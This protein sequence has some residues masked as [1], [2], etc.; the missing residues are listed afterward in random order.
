MNGNI[1]MLLKEAVSKDILKI[2]ISKR[3][4]KNLKDLKKAKNKA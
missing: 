3:M 2:L 4:L 1:Y